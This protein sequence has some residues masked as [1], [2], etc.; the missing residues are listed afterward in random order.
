M[1]SLITHQNVVPTGKSNAYRLKNMRIREEFQCPITYELLRDPVIAADGNTYERTAIE[2]WLAKSQTSPL[3]GEALDHGMVNPNRALKKIIQDLIEEGG[4]GLY[5]V[6][7]AMVGA[8]A[9]AK[10]SSG[11][12]RT[13]TNSIENGGCNAQSIDVK[14][15]PKVR[16]VDVF[17][18]KVLVLTGMGPPEVTEWFQK[19]FQLTPRGC[20]G[21]R[22]N[23]GRN[24][25]NKDTAPDSDVAVVSV[26]KKFL[27]EDMIVFKDG[28]IS[29]WHFEMSLVGPG[30]YG[31]RDL[32]SLGGTFLR[33][34]YNTAQF[35]LPLSVSSASSSSLTMSTRMCIPALGADK[36]TVML[37][38]LLPPT[39]DRPPG[40]R[41]WPYSMFMLGKHHFIVERIDSKF[42]ADGNKSY[43][44]AGAFISGMESSPALSS[45]SK[46]RDDKALQGVIR[47]TEDV[48]QQISRLGKESSSADGKVESKDDVVRG[49][50]L[51]LQKRLDELTSQLGSLDTQ[52]G[53]AD[54]KI[55]TNSNTFDP[56]RHP[57]DERRCV[58]TCI[59]PENSPEVGK[60]FVIGAGGAILGRKNAVCNDIHIRAE[61]KSSSLDSKESASDMS[62]CKTLLKPLLVS[63]SDT[64]I[65]SHHGR[66]IMD[67]RTGT[68]S[69]VDGAFN[70]T[71]E[72]NMSLT[73]SPLKHSANGTWLR[74]SAASKKSSWYEI[75]AGMEFQASLIRF[76]ISQGHNTIYEKEVN[77]N[78]A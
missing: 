30:T 26:E 22:N 43:V 6:D 64:A 59:A 13:R 14:E 73:Y 39:E 62:I 11:E 78:D 7:T 23:Y 29:R 48:L 52:E 46:E 36:S 21:G 16:C 47:D 63:L 34:P 75:R 19:S 74:L 67:P 1:A 33:V 10:I 77:E 70:V 9:A 24:L 20:M 72:E 58:I 69:L 49:G 18:E 56:K 57:Y 4:V 12:S 3:S 17:K 40:Q 25:I 38:S 8:A 66:I 65:S 5:I 54:A 53:Q 32:G 51:C 76:G 61:E 28:N 50:L 31:L 44:K 71:L 55:E 68:F 41:L 27:S 2:K 35:S 37:D 60:S 45:K 42:T 15:V